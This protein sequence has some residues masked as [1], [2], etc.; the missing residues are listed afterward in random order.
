MRMIINF[1]FYFCLSLSFGND[2]YKDNTILAKSF[3]IDFYVSILSA[4]YYN[5]LFAFKNKNDKD[6]LR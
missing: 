5:K 6:I 4:N 1:N 2:F 3:D